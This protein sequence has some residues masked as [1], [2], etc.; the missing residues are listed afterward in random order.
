MY[1]YIVDPQ[2]L[3]QRQFERIQSQLYSC[4][5]EFRIN[6]ETSRVTSLRTVQQLVDHALGRGV[7]TLVAVG[8]DDTLHDV[9]NALKGREAIIGF[10]PLEETEAG[11]VLGIKDVESGCKIIAGRRIMQLDLGLVNHPPRVDERTRV[12][13]G[14]AFL[15]RL[16]F[17]LH[18]PEINLNFRHIR[19][20]FALPT[21]EV[22]FATNEYA[23]SLKVIGG[24]IVNSRG[25]YKSKPLASPTD[26][27]LDVL[28]LPKL[29]RFSMLKYRKQIAN[30][31]YD[32]IPGSSL[33]HLSKL[34]IS[35]PE[36]L[37]LRIG[38]QIVA[39]TPATIE[40]APK[41]LKIIV[42]K[43]RMF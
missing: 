43:D 16:S 38:S 26:G 40:I 20:L 11:Q 12:E 13:A 22:K 17:G 7:K 29:S 34:E 9:I 10:I 42:G 28:L 1:Y 32:L 18:L 36:G 2:S 15:T 19:Q 14:S 37:P 30:G 23:A 25:D 31:F 4:L 27:I 3:N 21:F 35:S 24:Q 39:K 41:A 6:G 5:S 33:L 8:G